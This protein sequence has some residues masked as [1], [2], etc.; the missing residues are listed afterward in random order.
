ML[1]LVTKRLK[2]VRH[3]FEKVEAVYRLK[4]LATWV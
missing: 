1:Q 3:Y 2:C 4:Y